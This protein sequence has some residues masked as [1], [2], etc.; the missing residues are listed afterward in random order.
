VPPLQYTN[1]SPSPENIFVLH[2]MALTDTIFLA[3]IC[4]ILGYQLGSAQ[5]YS[6]LST[7]TDEEVVTSPQPEQTNPPTQP[8]PDGYWVGLHLHESSEEDESLRQ[9]LDNLGPDD[10][11]RSPIAP[12]NS[13][14]GPYYCHVHGCDAYAVH[15]STRCRHQQC[16]GHHCLHHCHSLCCPHRPARLYSK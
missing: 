14:G 8:H 5:H 15:P 9:P 1:I 7:Q 10:F 13:H 4:F 2:S 3:I 6:D 16:R 12:R 11:T